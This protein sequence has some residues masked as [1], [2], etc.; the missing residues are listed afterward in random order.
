MDRPWACLECGA[1]QAAGGECARCRRD[2]T[3]DLRDEKVRELARD[4][5]DRLSHQ[6]E[7]RLRF[8]G[9]AVGMAVVF[10]AW[11]VPGYWSLRNSTFALPF[12]LD[13]ILLMAGIGLGVLAVLGRSKKKRF[14]YLDDDL[15]VRS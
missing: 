7:K 12:F 15:N 13:Q 6:R 14:P 2:D 8:V 4:I 10:A 5:E 11:L 1:R 3:A 9:V